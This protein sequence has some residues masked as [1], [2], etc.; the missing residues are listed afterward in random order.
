MNFIQALNLGL[1]LLSDE[2]HA[3]MVVG[4][5]IIKDEISND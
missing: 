1:M 4:T 3:R 2:N 5:S